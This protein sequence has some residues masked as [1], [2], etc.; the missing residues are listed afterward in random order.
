MEPCHVIK[1]GTRNPDLLLLG[2]EFGLWVSVDRG[3]SWSKLKSNFPTVSVHDIAIHPRELDAILGTHGRSI[4]T[5]NV[6]GL[7]GLTAENLAKDAVVFKPQNVLNFGRITGGGFD[8]NRLWV[9]QN[10]QPGTDIMYYL[11]ADVEGDVKIE[12][13]DAGG[14]QIVELTG[15][16]KA[17]LNVVRWTA[18]RQGRVV[19]AGD[20]RVVLKAGGKEYATF[21]TVEDVSG[22]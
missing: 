1:E 2:T 9:A 12:V 7:E 16:N 20:Y 4:W 19:P 22:G 18:R 17:G 5:V 15:S 3:K 21:V 14:A 10:T 6:S 11:K 13:S 8:G